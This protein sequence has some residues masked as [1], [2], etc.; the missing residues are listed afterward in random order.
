VVS[1]C[2]HRSTTKTREPGFWTTVLC[3]ELKI[4][5]LPLKKNVFFHTFALLVAITFCIDSG[6]LLASISVP[7]WELVGITFYVFSWSIF[8]WI[9]ECVFDRFLSKTAF[10]TLVHVEP[11]CLFFRYF[12]AGAPFD[13]LCV[14]YASI[15]IP[16]C[17]IWVPFGNRL[18]DLGFLMEPV[19]SLWGHMTPA[20][21]PQNKNK[22]NIHL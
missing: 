14:V 16:F 11:F 3:S 8:K 18:V 22:E 17:S 19:W 1:A 7:F 4:K 13:D 15:L 20:R 10:K 5:F 12:S 6:W 21:Y 2:R 9:F